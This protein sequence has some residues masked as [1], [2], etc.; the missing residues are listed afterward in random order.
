M[1]TYSEG[2][3]GVITMKSIELKG[4]ISPILTPMYE[5]ESINF[6]E[7]RHQ[8]DRMIDNGI[9]GIFPFGTNGE[10]YILS[11]EEKKQVLEVVVYQA[12]GRVPIYA[13]SGAI[14]YERN[15]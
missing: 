9:H 15:D 4:I 2:R 1:K 3:K 10:G 6:E 11:A 5:D 7:L 12:A 13:G 8:V 14:F